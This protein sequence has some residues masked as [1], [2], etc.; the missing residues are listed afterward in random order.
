MVVAY[1]IT[2][3]WSDL[4]MLNIFIVE[5]VFWRSGGFD[6]CWNI[7]ALANIS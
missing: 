3:F 2:D 7:I 1:S 6:K 4:L 5:E